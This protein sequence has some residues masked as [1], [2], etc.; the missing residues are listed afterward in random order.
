MLQEFGITQEQY[1]DV[2][3]KQYVKKFGKLGEAVVNSNMEVMT[4]G[5]EQVKEIAI[6]ELA[7]AD[8]LQPARRGAAADS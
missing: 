1:R 8:Q 4:Q 3:D 2:V 7:A 5:F 6:G